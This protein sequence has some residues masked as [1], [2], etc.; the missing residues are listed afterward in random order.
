[1]IVT[2]NTYLNFKSLSLYTNIENKI[3]VA[4]KPTKKALDC[5]NNPQSMKNREIKMSLFFLLSFIKYREIKIVIPNK[6]I[7]PVPLEPIVK[8]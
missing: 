6:H 7:R 3:T 8:V 5:V 1:M 4:A 2:P